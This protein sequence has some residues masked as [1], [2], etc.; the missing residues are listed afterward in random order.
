MHT[1]LSISTQLQT[2]MNTDGWVFNDV[3]DEILCG[4]C[5]QEIQDE[6]EQ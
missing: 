2:V 6:K 3:D 5:I 4:T 1:F